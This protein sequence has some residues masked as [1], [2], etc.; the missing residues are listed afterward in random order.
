M[1]TKRQVKAILRKAGVEVS[2]R[3]VTG[4]YAYRKFPEFL[5]PFDW[6]IELIKGSPDVFLDELD[7]LYGENGILCLKHQA[8]R[9]DPKKPN[10]IKV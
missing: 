1:Y 3:P 10:P 9:I 4:V 2:I 5:T 7:S 6:I 8:Y